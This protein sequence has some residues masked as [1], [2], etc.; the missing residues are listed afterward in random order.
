MFTCKAYE[1]LPTCGTKTKEGLSWIKSESLS[2]PEPMPMEVHAQ[3]SLKT[4]SHKWLQIQSRI[5]G[6]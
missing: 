2:D 4:E 1:L 6:Q 5:S 3:P